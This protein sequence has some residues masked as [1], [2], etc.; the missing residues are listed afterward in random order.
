LLDLWKHYSSLKQ[1]KTA[2]LL[3]KSSIYTANTERHCSWYLSSPHLTELT[4]KTIFAIDFQ[5]NA[6]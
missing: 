3:R 4:P 6:I 1:F 5:K 2:A